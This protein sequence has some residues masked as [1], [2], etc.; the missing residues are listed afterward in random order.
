M[1]ELIIGIVFIGLG[2]LFF[3]N[4]KNIGEGMAK[5]Y[6]KLYTERNLKVMFRACG[7][8]LVLGGLILIF[9]K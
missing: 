2:L 9:L 8:I 7:V 3:F 1:K 5:F 6:R 4:N